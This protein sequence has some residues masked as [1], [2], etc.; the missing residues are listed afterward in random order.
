MH[1]FK[2]IVRDHAAR[3]GAAG[4]AQ[5]AIDELAGHLEDIYL[6]ARAAVIASASLCPARRAS[7]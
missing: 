5:H 7:R 6:D 2:K 3:T 1:D 4:L